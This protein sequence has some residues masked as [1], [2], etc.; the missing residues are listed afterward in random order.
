MNAHVVYTLLALAHLWVFYSVCLSCNCSYYCR[1]FCANKHTQT[2]QCLQVHETKT[3]TASITD[4]R[5]LVWPWDSDTISVIVDVVLLFLHLCLVQPW[6]VAWLV[7][8]EEPTLQHNTKE[9]FFSYWYCSLNVK[10]S[11]GTEKSK[12][13]KVGNFYSAV[14]TS[15]AWDQQCFII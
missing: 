12:K 4:N 11:T 7:P 5:L 14:Y 3:D 15:P 10:N 2:T 1:H 8:L 13:A 9:H 6:V